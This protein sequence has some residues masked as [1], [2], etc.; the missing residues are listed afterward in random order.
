MKKIITA[1]LII[2]C[3]VGIVY[4]VKSSEYRDT[5]EY[6]IVSA[7][8]WV[9]K[10]ESGVFTTK[11][12]TTTHVEIIYKTNDNYEKINVVPND[13]FIEPETKVVHKKGHLSP[14]I[15]MTTEFYQ[16]LFK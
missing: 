16:S 8:V 2:G 12:N 14:M 4:L 3:I 9:D 11:V 15:Y 1:L 7:R 10:Q 6:G 13:I 5:K